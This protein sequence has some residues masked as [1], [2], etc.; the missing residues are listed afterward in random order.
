MG[1]W[2]FSNTKDGV[3]AEYFHVNEA[4]ANMAKIPDDVPDEAAVY[5]ADMMSTGFAGAEEANIP[6]G[7]SAVVFALGPVGLM[8]VAGAKFRGAGVIVGVDS[9]PKR[10]ELAKFYAAD[11]I[12][13]PA[14]E[15]AVARIMDLTAGLGV[16][17]SIE[18][19]G[20]DTH[21][22]TPLRSQ[23]LAEQYQM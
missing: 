17:G 20:A 12:V 13:D 11:L 9:V 10:Q 5:V 1:G 21:L 15:N 7:G 23:S 22:R 14:K 2:K 19:L 3:F 8:A 4:D 6:I 16:D 18:A